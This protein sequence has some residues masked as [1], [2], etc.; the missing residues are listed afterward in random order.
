MGKT[1]VEKIFSNKLNTDIVAGNTVFAPVDLTVGTDGTVPLAIDV[2]NGLP[3]ARIMNPEKLVFVNDH[4]VPAKDI[5]SANLAKTMKEFAR[6]H[7]VEH[8]YEVGRSGIC[9]V[10]V[11]EKGLIF[12]GDIVVGADSHTCTYGA[13]GAFASG[14]GSTDMVCAW[15]L[16]MLWFRVPESIRVEFS[17]RLKENVTAKDVIL[18]LIGQIGVDGA[19]YKS[20]E[21]HGSLMQ[22]LDSSARFTLCN[23]AVEMGAKSAIILPDEI[24]LDYLESRR[25]GS[26]NRAIPDLDPDHDAIYESKIEIDVSELE[27]VIA[28]PHD[29]SNVLPAR[30][31]AGTRIDQVVLGSC[32]NGRI[33]D[34]RQAHR[35]LMGKNVHER[36]RLILIP[37]SPE[38]FK[39]IA[40]EGMLG[41]FIEAG[42]VISPPTCGPCIGGHMGVLAKGEKGLF[43]T[44]R[45]FLGR[46]GDPD[47]E[48]YLC[49]PVIAAYSAIY[50]EIQVPD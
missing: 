7:N 24:M 8:Y 48:V 39:Q 49:S 27:P 32:T 35:I 25:H 12:P 46:N 47:S 26:R 34:F 5:Q 42:A 16:G 1:I 38:V 43:T 10:I 19:T 37:G 23:M 29:P 28:C 15:V 22:L 18:Y 40:D 36:T 2:F 21:F 13:L 44:N 30:D 31:L 45:N 11:P 20:L 6:L 14:I 17:G 41:T 33:E 4:F 3:D 9:H 50:G